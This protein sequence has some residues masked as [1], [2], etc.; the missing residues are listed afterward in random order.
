MAILRPYGILMA[1]IAPYIPY[2]VPPEQPWWA[3]QLTRMPLLGKNHRNRLIL[4]SIGAEFCEIA[5]SDFMMMKPLEFFQ[6]LL[7]S[8]IFSRPSHDLPGVLADAV[9]VTSRFQVLP[10]DALKMLMLWSPYKLTLMICQYGQY[11]RVCCVKWYGRPWVWEFRSTPVRYSVNS[12][13]V[14]LS[15]SSI[16]IAAA[17]ISVTYCISIYFI[18]F[19]YLFV[20]WQSQSFFQATWFHGFKDIGIFLTASRSL[21]RRWLERD[22][23]PWG[24]RAVPSCFVIRGLETEKICSW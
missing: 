24:Q 21:E 5:S 9:F 2:R 11:G 14:L 3:E 7:I 22:P 1:T 15:L 8:V 19:L 10:I 18:L 23:V 6:N 17:Q 4:T 12:G 16:L 13:I 20:A